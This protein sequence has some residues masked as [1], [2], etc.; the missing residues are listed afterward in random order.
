[1]L[2]IRHS[3]RCQY[4]G[5]WVERHNKCRV[6]TCYNCY[7]RRLKE[8]RLRHI[9]KAL[10]GEGYRECPTC[11]KAFLPKKVTSKY[12][13]R[14]CCRPPQTVRVHFNKP[15]PNCGNIFLSRRKFCSKRCGAQYRY[16][17]G[18]SNLRRSVVLLDHEKESKQGGSD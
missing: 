4:C 5:D 3:L 16:D 6:V 9:K 17:T 7:Q 12:C 8:N 10:L 11:L 15:C 13:S 14:K 1:M 18:R 2:K